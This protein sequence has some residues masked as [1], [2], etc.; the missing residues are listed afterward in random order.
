MKNTFL[1][2]KEAVFKG[3]QKKNIQLTDTYL[4]RLNY[5]LRIIKDNGFSDY[6]KLYSYIISICNEL[7]ILRSYGRNTALN[8]LVNYCLDITKLDPVEYSLIFERFILPSQQQ[9]PD[10]DIDIPSGY[11]DL[12][13][14]NFKTKHPEY[15][16]YYIALIPHY[17]SNY[18]T[19]SYNGV[20]VKKHPCGVIFTRERISKDTFNLNGYDYYFVNDTSTDHF[21]K[22][23]IDLVELDYLNKIQ[24]IVNIVGDD[25][26]PYK[27]PLND[28]QVFKSLTEHNLAHVF[29]ISSETVQD[30]LSQFSPTSIQ[31]LAFI[32]AMLHKDIAT[33]I[34]Q[35]ILHKEN[36]KLLPELSSSTINNILHET[37]FMLVYQET[38]LNLCQLIAGMEYDEAEKYRKVLS[39][40]NAAP[41]NIA[42][43]IDNFK[44][45]AKSS[46]VLSEDE[47]EQILDKIISSHKSALPKGHIYSYT[48]I[49]YWGA[50]YKTYFEDVFRNIFSDLL[51]NKNK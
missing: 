47:V 18:V 24:Q 23:K 22:S 26:H 1:E 16:V 45:K 4:D 6:F 42:L 40:F 35:I 28:P 13:I 49:S 11:L 32:K 7:N 12:I 46:K 9:Q 31:D 27:L 5:E 3:A 29:Q 51:P 37:Y 20:V 14:T 33:Y 30:I 38:F 2:L 39:R 44:E 25:Y 21:Y 19:I 8:S 50:Y 43:F 10:V 34:P 17:E 36:I 41:E 15:F 48:I